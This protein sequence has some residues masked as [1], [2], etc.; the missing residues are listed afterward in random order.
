VTEWEARFRCAGGAEG[1]EEGATDWGRGAPEWREGPGIAGIGIWS[2]SMGGCG[3][4]QSARG[5][6]SLLLLTWLLP[7]VKQSTALLSHTELIVATI[8]II[9]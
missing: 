4:Q 9:L 6:A 7:N 2:E 3:E 1:A 8:A 5:Q